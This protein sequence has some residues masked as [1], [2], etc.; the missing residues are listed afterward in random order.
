MFS[1]CRDYVYPLQDGAGVEP[2]LRPSK[3]GIVRRPVELANKYQKDPLRMPHRVRKKRRNE[4]RSDKETV[5]V[6]KFKFSREDYDF[7]IGTGKWM[8]G[9]TGFSWGGTL[10]PRDPFAHFNGIDIGAIEGI[11]VE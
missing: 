2:F 6:K 10:M 3:W 1:Y 11:T 7:L 9:A 5:I 4:D 8:P